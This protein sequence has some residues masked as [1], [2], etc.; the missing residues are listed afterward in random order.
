MLAWSDSGEEPLQG[1]RLVT[2]HYV[3]TGG[4]RVGEHS[5]LFFFCE[6]LFLF[7]LQNIIHIF[8]HN[9]LHTDYYIMDLKKQ[10]K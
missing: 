1:C 4:K 3:L 8:K 6:I 5:G 10:I 7:F 9:Y 2:S